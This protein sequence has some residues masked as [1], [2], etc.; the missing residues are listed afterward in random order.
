MAIVSENFARELGGDPASALGLRIRPP[1]DSSDWREIIGV[2]QDVKEDAL[3]TAAPSIVYWPAF[4]VNAFG[5]EAFGYPAMAYV[6][7]SDR[8]GTVTFNTEIRD[9][10]W[11]VNRDVPIARERTM[12]DLYAGSLAQTSVALVPQIAR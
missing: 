8:T 9:A 2:V 1:V 12:Q 7:R 3:Y 10:I 5:S 6:I 11:S 4:M